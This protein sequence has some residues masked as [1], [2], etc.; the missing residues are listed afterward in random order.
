MDGLVEMI[1]IDEGLMRKEVAFQIAPG[2]LDVVQFRGVFR[3]PFN[4][5]PIP[6]SERGPR[7]LAGMDGAIVEN[8][9]DRFVAPAGALPVA[10]VAAAEE[11]NNAAPAPGGAGIDG[12]LRVSAVESP[13]HRPLL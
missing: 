6:V 12:E 1:D 2:S 4:G 13:D 11:C 5:Q 7:G 3:Q 9:D 10:R 8:K